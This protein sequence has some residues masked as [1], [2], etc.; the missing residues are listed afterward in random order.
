MNTKHHCSRRES[1]HWCIH[2]HDDASSA[3]PRFVFIERSK[4]TI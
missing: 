2:Y 4:I 3:M 1:A